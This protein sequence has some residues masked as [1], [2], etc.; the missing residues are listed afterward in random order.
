MAIS[1]RTGVRFL[2]LLVWHP[3]DVDTFCQIEMDLAKA[4]LER[5]EELARD[6]RFA[7]MTA[8]LKRR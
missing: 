6:A 2:D 7:E 3:R 4:E 8:Q 5:Q 1:I